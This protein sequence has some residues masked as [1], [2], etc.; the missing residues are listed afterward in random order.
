MTKN[1]S[2]EELRK[3]VAELEKQNETLQYEAMKYRTLF[4]SLPHGITVSDAQ[5]NIVEANSISEQLLGIRKEE[6]KKRDI[7]GQEWRI[8]RKDGTDMPPDEWASVIALKENRMVAGCEMGIARP[9]SRTTWLNVTAAPLEIEGYGVVI[10]YNDITKAKQTQDALDF[11]R[12]QLLSIFDSIPA[13]IDILDPKTHEILYMNKYARDLLGKD[14]V[15][16]KCYQVFHNYTDKCSFCNNDELLEMNDESVISWEYYSEPFD[17]HFMTTNRLIK[18]PDG[19]RVKLEMSIDISDRLKMR[20]ALRESEERYKKLIDTIPY[21]IEELDLDGKRVFVNGS[22]CKMLGYNYR[23]ITEK[24]IWDN[25]PTAAHIQKLKDYFEYIKSEQPPPEKY[26]SKK[27]KKDGTVIDVNIDWNYLYNDNDK[28]V[29]FLSVVTD[30]SERLRH[31]NENYLLLS[32]YKQKAIEMEALFNGT[33]I[34]LEEDDFKSTARKIFD[35]CR[36][37]TG[38]KS[39]YVALLSDDGAENEVLFLESGGLPCD[40]NPELPMPIRGLRAEAYRFGKAVYDNDFANSKWMKYMPKGHVHLRNVL[41]GPLKD[42][43]KTVGLIGLANKDGN[44]NKNDAKMV[45]AF[46]ELAA[47]ALKQ[48]TIQEALQESEK[49]YR[50]TQ[51]LEAIGN[52]AGGIAHDFNNI[53]SSIIGYTELSLDDVKKGSALEDNLNEVYTAGKRARDLVKQI[54]T[55]ARQLDTEF[56]PIVVR[57][58]AKEVLKLLRSTIPSD[59]EIEDNLQSDS[60]VLGDTTQIHQLFMNLC[61]NAA[62]AMEGSGGKLVVELIDTFLDSSFA[63]KYKGINPGNFLEIKISDTGEGISSD[64]IEHVFDPYYTTKAAEKGTGMGLATVHGIVKAY[65]GEI[66]VESKVGEGTTFTIYLPVTKKRT[67]SEKY[68]SKPLPSG[69]ERL[70]ILDDE[71]PIAK[72]AS[73]ILKRLGYVTTVRTSSLEA[74]ELFKRR[75]N[76]FDLVITDM[77]MPNMTGDK[78]AIELIKIRPDIPIILS[79]GYSS[80]ISEDRAKELGIRAFSMKPLAKQ[81]LAET[82]RKVL[83]EA[84]GQSRS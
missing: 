50:Q 63:H 81:N 32:K 58:V 26:I 75:P 24:Y 36:R 34:L 2:Y 20:K 39:G 16:L 35:I 56:K 61:T 8:I 73:Q 21:G 64:H 45:T 72:M 43:G 51:K 33:R 11:A 19:R 78:L 3:R 44:F 18:W 28:L 42:S 22:Y 17:R 80:R 5:G 71:P 69:T 60:L 15:G 48:S 46:G 30:I 52:L 74:L 66:I 9:D 55:F 79:T 82:V 65:N 62:Q 7:A 12:N 83:D 67:E 47:I 76:D 49:R 6:H 57:N 41:F 37:L 40:V 31:Q 70:L 23:E 38:A 68:Q 77:T 14:G 84:K 53:L 13:L 59:I 27:V 10:I 25:E 54:L 4:D 29:G 1:A